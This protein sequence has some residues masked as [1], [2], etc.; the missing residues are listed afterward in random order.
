MKFVFKVAVLKIVMNRIECPQNER[1][2]VKEF[3]GR[4]E[5]V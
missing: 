2:V 5:R 3:T 4:S 1:E